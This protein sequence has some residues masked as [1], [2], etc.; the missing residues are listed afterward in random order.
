MARS[1]GGETATWKRETVEDGG[2]VA[3]LPIRHE[4]RRWN[5]TSL[6]LRCCP[7]RHEVVD[8]DKKKQCVDDDAIRRAR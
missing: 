7:R 1:L 5:I 2:A 6:P 3:L 4:S 8:K